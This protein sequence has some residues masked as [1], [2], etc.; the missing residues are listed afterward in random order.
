[1]LQSDG[2]HKRALADAAASAMQVLPR[3]ALAAVADAIA[4]R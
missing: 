4:R 2:A 3:R 1:M